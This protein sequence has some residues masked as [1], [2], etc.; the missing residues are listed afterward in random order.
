M[1]CW[2]AAVD[3]TPTQTL[4]RLLER[5]DHTSAVSVL[6]PVEV[7]PCMD[8][9]SAKEMKLHSYSR[10]APHTLLQTSAKHCQTDCT[11][12]SST[13]RQALSTTFNFFTLNST[14]EFSS[15]SQQT[16]WEPNL[17]QND[18]CNVNA[19]FL[20]AMHVCSTFRH[21]PHP[22]GY[23]GANFISFAASIAQLAHG[24]KL[25]TQSLTHPAYLM[26]REPKLLLWNYESS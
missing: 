16:C 22:L 10:T 7:W 8:R 26:L 5:L 24:E 17:K 23:L 6:V 13:T 2:R 25:H 11:L 3:V 12:Y 18:S 21:H 15:I 1:R 14:P 20:C 19:S 4:C 9:T